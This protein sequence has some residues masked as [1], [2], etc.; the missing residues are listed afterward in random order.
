VEAWDNLDQTLVRCSLAVF[1][2]S[3]CDAWGICC[4][5]SV[6]VVLPTGLVSWDR[7]WVV[8]LRPKAGQSLG[9]ETVS[10]NSWWTRFLVRFL[11]QKT[12][13][14][15][16]PQLPSVSTLEAWARASSSDARVRPSVSHLSHIRC[17]AKS[18]LQCIAHFQRDLTEQPTKPFFASVTTIS[19]P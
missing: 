18:R 15:M 2:D 8:V 12:V 17:H 3:W 4:L 11:F 16:R 19:S 6:Q 5:E 10:T 9:P 1:L 14:K 7:F 13:P